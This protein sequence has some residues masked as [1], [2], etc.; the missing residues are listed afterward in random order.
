MRRPHSQPCRSWKPEPNI[1]KAPFNVVQCGP[2]NASESVSSQSM[3]IHVLLSIRVKMKELEHVDYEKTQ[4][5]GS[6][7]RYRVRLRVYR[8]VINQFTKDDDCEA[9]KPL[10]EVLNMK[11]RKS[12]RKA[13]RE[14][15]FF[16]STPVSL[17]AWR[18]RSMLI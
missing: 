2:R 5:N 9:A 14:R 7:E 4:T 17:V 11:W 15:G 1:V 18:R 8:N 12:D 10:R 16:G 3:K 6:V 13:A